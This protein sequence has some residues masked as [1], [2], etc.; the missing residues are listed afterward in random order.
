MF[1]KIQPLFYGIKVIFSK[2][3]LVYIVLQYVLGFLQRAY[4]MFNEKSV[5]GNTDVYI[6]SN[7]RF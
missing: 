1:Y 3:R 2:I 6:L 5:I 7:D 4:I